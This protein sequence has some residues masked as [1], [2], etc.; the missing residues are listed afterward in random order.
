MIVMEM[1]KNKSYTFYL[2]D[3]SLPIPGKP[4]CFLSLKIDFS[5]TLS[6]FF[7]GLHPKDGKEENE[8]VREGGG[9][10]KGMEKK[11]RR[12]TNKGGSPKLVY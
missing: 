3:F 1:S 7:L 5:G 11:R 8:C 12:N 4:L 9:G 2:L 6:L 10:W